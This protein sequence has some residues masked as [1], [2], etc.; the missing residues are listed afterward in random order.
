MFLGLERH[1]ANHLA[2]I[3]DEDNV[4]TYGNV[5]EKTG[6]LS[7]SIESRSLIFC[8][9][10]NT[11]GSLLGYLSFI[12][13]GAVPLNLSSKTEAGLLEA[14]I[15]E[16][17]PAY[18]WCPEDMAG[19]FTY[20]P[21]RSELGY[22]L[23]KTGNEIY[24]LNDRL[25]FLMTT[26]GTTGSPKLVRYARG[27]LEANARNVAEA[28]GWTEEERPVCD[29]GMHYT[30][31]LNVI[32]THLYTGAC[33]LLTGHNLVS[34]DFWDYIARHK[35][36]NFTGVP[37]S[38][39]IL[40]RL[41]FERM[42]LPALSTLAQGGGRLTEPRFTELAEHA[43]KTGRRFIATFGT[44]ETSAR[45]SY[46]PSELA[47]EKTCSIGHEI[48]EVRMFL[49]DPEG[50]VLD[51]T[52]AEGELCCS[53]PNVTMGYAYN[54]ADL[55]KGDEFRGIYHSGD[56]A[57]R[58]K[59]G[60]YFITGRLS[61]FLKLLGYRVSLDETE[62]LVEG[63]FGIEC[64]CTGSDDRMSIFITEAGL[65]GEV[66]DFLSRKTGLFSSLFNVE[67]VDIIPRNEH[68]KTAYN[69]L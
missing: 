2:I 18:I 48:P 57:R 24:P 61:R 17:L 63:R 45:V 6:E 38:Y 50:R 58:D 30:M 10:R 64:A 33:V 3:D 22:V 40:H 51:E 20:Q 7:R 21:V 65:T 59:D 29:L 23:L 35:A 19:K 1:D 15:G 42:N 4:L 54:K 56:I 26:S 8:L 67:A 41:H 16:Y 60:C 47:L 46:L 5:I 49:I 12:E 27:N 14:L 34:S 13:G 28:F 36:T 43:S 55:L 66:R 9:S 44:T 62:R 68:G 52:E 31:G 53:G 25:E 11:A 37:F 69:M 39:E 32:N